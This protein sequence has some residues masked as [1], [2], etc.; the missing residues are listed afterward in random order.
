MIS[1]E[2]FRLL[3]ALEKNGPIKADKITAPSV[4]EL[5]A[6]GLLVKQDDLFEISPIG[7][8]KLEPYRVKRA[9]IMAAGFGS[10]MLPA[11]KDTPKPLVEVNGRRIIETLL[12]ALVAAEIKDI[13]VI[14]GYQR[15]KFKSLLANYPFLKFVTN[16]DYVNCNNISSMMKVL[17]CLDR[18]TYICEAD[19]YVTNPAIIS[20][21]QYDSNILGYYC[22]E[23]T[24]WCFKLQAGYVTDYRQGNTDC[25]NEYGISYWIKEDCAQLRRDLPAVYAQPE[26]SQQFWE[27]VPLKWCHENY[28]VRLRECQKE[29]IV[30]ID[31]YQELLQIRQK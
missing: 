6:G 8:E 25:Y 12:D 19:L 31:S 4:A 22:Q 24:D 27:S 21:Y 15:Q 20:K 11:T 3:T 2:Q 26:G 9:I 28:Q 7:I 16:D 18:G 29:D 13:T 10:R 14:V 17:D 5:L 30:E 23:T 1:R